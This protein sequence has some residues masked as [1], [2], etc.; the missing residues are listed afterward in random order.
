MSSTWVSEEEGT[1]LC[2]GSKQLERSPTWGEG[3]MRRPPWPKYRPPQ[4][5]EPLLVVDNKA[6]EMDNKKL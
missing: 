3:L 2:V 4:H 5:K 6:G 1:A